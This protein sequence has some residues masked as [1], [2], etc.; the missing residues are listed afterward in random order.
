MVGGRWLTWRR[1]RAVIVDSADCRRRAY[2]IRSAWLIFQFSRQLLNGLSDEFIDLKV[3][4]LRLE[5]EILRSLVSYCR[6]RLVG[7][8]ETPTSKGAERLTE[9]L[10]G[11]S[12]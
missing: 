8:L 3:L 10:S 5:R 2:S 6:G 4:G 11:V 1:R 9:S 7:Y 12:V